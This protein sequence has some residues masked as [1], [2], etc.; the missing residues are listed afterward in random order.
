[1]SSR[2][3]TVEDKN[4]WTRRV[5]FGFPAVFVLTGWLVVSW[6]QIGW[7]QDDNRGITDPDQTSGKERVPRHSMLLWKILLE[8]HLVYIYGAGIRH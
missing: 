8:L 6:I 5:R 2:V 4:L 3:G 7:S 1:M